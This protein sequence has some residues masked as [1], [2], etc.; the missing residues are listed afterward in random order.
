MYISTRIPGGGVGNWKT[1]LRT[2]AKSGMRNKLTMPWK[3]WEES[4]GQAMAKPKAVSAKETR[5][6][7]YSNQQ[8]LR[9]LGSV[10]R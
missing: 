1:G 9:P 3:A 8:D 7:Y 5:K 10:H 6:D 4:M 2:S